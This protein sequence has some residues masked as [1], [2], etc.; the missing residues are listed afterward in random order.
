VRASGA[1]TELIGNPG[2]G[3]TLAFGSNP[4]GR[5]LVGVTAVGIVVTVSV[6]GAIAGELLL[7]VGLLASGT[8]GSFEAV[9]L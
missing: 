9:F 8:I 4:V 2:K 3:H 1:E 6:A 5:S 7:G